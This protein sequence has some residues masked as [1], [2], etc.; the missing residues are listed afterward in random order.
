MGFA[1]MLVNADRADIVYRNP[2]AAMPSVKERTLRLRA[3]RILASA[4][5][6]RRHSF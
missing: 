5:P 1:K 6:G 2:M 3:S 4:I